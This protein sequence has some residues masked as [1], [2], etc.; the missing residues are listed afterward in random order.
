M[1]NGILF[2]N[3]NVKTIFMPDPKQ[4]SHIPSKKKTSPKETKKR[5][6][7]STSSWSKHISSNELEMN[8]HLKILENDDKCPKKNII[9]REIKYKID[10]YR[11]QDHDKKKFDFTK[12]VDLEFVIEHLKKCNETC[13]YCKEKV[14]V[15]YETS[16]DPKQW[17]LERIYNDKGHN[18]DNVEICCLSCNIKRRTMFHEKFRFTK[19]TKFIK[20]SENGSSTPL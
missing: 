8:Q 14:K 16:R 7:S 6:V 20:V 9:L 10:G 13:Y 4:R 18:K 15:L 1:H 3:E 17:T 5:I 11:S 2:E 19:Q 12:F